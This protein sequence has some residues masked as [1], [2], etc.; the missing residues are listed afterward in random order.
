M[1]KSLNFI[2]V[3]E[4]IYELY[5]KMCAKRAIRVIHTILTFG[6]LHIYI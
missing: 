3:I 2:R 5:L 4:I 1:M 6:I